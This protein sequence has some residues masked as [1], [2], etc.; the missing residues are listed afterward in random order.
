M[1]FITLVKYLR[2]LKEK[3][4]QKQKQYMYNRDM[5]FTAIEMDNYKLAKIILSAGKLPVTCSNISGATPLTAVCQETLCSDKKE[6]LK[7]VN[8]LLQRKTSLEMRDI[9][10]KTAH[11]YII[12][13]G[14][15]DIGRLYDEHLISSSP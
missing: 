1:C 4:G 14:F 8:F 12:E 3:K 7:F 9:Y 6:K 10:G 5:L 13:N 15:D 2:K 11:D